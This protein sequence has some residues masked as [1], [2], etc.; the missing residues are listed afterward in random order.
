MKTKKKGAEKQE[1][2]IGLCVSTMVA[3]LAW[4]WQP[5]WELAGIWHSG[6]GIF[7]PKS[8]IPGSLADMFPAPLIFML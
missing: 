2:V 7:M 8:M 1:M 6:K 5:I 4:I 3:E